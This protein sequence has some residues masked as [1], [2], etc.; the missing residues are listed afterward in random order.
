MLKGQNG[1]AGVESSRMSPRN[2]GPSWLSLW[3][4]CAIGFVVSFGGLWPGYGW[5]SWVWGSDEGVNEGKQKLTLETTEGQ[6]RTPSQLLESIA[7]VLNRPR[8]KDSEGGRWV[9]WERAGTSNYHLVT[10][11]FEE[12]QQR[13][14]YDNRP[15]SKKQTPSEKP[16]VLPPFT[17]LLNFPDT[18]VRLISWC[19]QNIFLW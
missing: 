7:H 11:K 12:R 17:G 9:G 5:G 16:E 4:V 3:R 6:L 18:V 10:L 1:A 14:G 15:P 8:M 13:R 19:Q 2:L